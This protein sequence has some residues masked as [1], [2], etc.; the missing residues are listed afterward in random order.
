MSNYSDLI[1]RG[2]VYELVCKWCEKCT[3]NPNYDCAIYQDFCAIIGD[4]GL[5]PA[6]NTV[7]VVRCKDCKNYK[8]DKCLEVKGVNYHWCIRHG[9]R[10]EQYYCADGDRRKSDD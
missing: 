10:T 4:I 2:D 9:Y 3:D 6:A 5:I 7:E 1:K 8:I